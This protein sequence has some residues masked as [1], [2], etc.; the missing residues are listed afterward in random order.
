MSTRHLLLSLAVL[1]GLTACEPARNDSFKS[2]SAMPAAVSCQDAPQLRQRSADD[3]HTGES[4]KSAQ[5]KIIANGRASYFAGLATVADL[6]CKAPAAQTGP[7]LTQAFAAIQRAE[8]TKSFYE[9]AVALSEANL[10]VTETIA[11]LL[12]QMPTASSK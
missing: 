8:E 6:M 4:T 5:E 1:G 9:K 10:R 11:A 3:R 7:T 12:Q 2:A